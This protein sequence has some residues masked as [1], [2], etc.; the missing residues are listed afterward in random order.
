MP[1]TWVEQTI[2]GCTKYHKILVTNTTPPTHMI[3][4]TITGEGDA[5]HIEVLGRHLSNDAPALSILKGLPKNTTLKRK[6]QLIDRL[7]LCSGN[8]DPSMLALADR[9]GKFYNIRGALVAEVE[10]KTIRHVKCEVLIDK[11]KGCRACERQN[12]S[13]GE[14]KL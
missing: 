7:K 11:G 1:E 8:S 5:L 14:T 10:Q 9:G 3:S 13:E 12:F 6:V 4:H 2:E